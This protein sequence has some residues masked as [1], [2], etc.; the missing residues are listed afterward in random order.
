MSPR[1]PALAILLGMALAACSLAGDITPP[2]GARPFRPISAT[3][4]P[5]TIAANPPA[6]PGSGVLPVSRELDFRPSAAAGARIYAE[7]C[8]DCHGPTGQGDGVRAAQIP[9][10]IPMPRFADPNLGKEATPQEWFDV[11]TNGRLERFMPPFNQ[12][13]SDADRWNVVAYIITLAVPPE[14]IERGRAVY[15]ANCAA[16]HGPAGRGDGPQAQGALTDLSAPGYF[17]GR[18]PADLLAAIGARSPIPD[19]TFDGALT[20]ADREAVVDYVRT[21]AYDYAAPDA[22]LITDGPAQTRTLTGVIRNGTA[23]AVT[24]PNLSVNLIGFESGLGIVAALTVTADAT[25]AFT[26]TDVPVADGREF[27][28]ATDYDGVTYYSPVSSLDGSEM[29]LM[30]Y[31]RTDDAGALRIEHVHTFILFE[32]PNEV[33]I[34]QWLIITNAGDKTFAP[35][36]GRTVAITLPPGAYG[37]NVREGEEG[38]TFFR[39]DTGFAD[40][41]PVLPGSG[42]AQ[43]FYSFKLPWNGALD[44]SQPLPY[45]V[46]SVNVFLGDMS[47]TLTGPQFIKTEAQEVQGMLFQSYARAGL[48]AGEPLTFRLSSGTMA[49]VAN[50][51]GRL[52]SVA[53]TSGLAL[54]VVVLSATLLGVGVWWWRNAR[55]AGGGR[56]TGGRRQADGQRRTVDGGQATRSR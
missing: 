29:Q 4:I 9:G 8:A 53:D 54:G 24:P 26:F 44:F 32:T 17:A 30:V 47:V 36:D 49:S 6:T 38:V 55:Q 27:V 12:S 43:L 13:L 40:T 46:N 56:R 14:Q 45:P 20:E 50:T 1:L 28:V 35:A 37:L 5:A 7:K 34:G 39:T 18:T 41:A 19:H 16:C 23:G 2:P 3:P 31:E 21:L 33:T 48:S 52:F 11:V 15:E 51:L 10:N 42:T 25:G 22:A